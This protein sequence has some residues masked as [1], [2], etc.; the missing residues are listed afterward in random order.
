MWF[1]QQTF[2]LITSVITSSS[3]T[4]SSYGKLGFNIRQKASAFFIYSGG[5]IE[6]HLKSSKNVK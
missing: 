3:I 1:V 5:A 4:A 6:M 2:A